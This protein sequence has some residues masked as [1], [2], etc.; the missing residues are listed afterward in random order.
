MFS[1]R[2]AERADAALLSTLGERLFRAAFGASNTDEDMQLYV[3]SAFSA[4]RQERELADA[5]TRTWLVEVESGAEIGYAMVRL[6]A[7]G[8]D[9]DAK[10]TVENVRFYVDTAFHGR[11]VASAL[12]NT[13]IE[14]AREW[15]CDQLWL[16]VWDKNARAIAFYK[17]SG[18]RVVGTQRFRLGNDRQRDFV[19]VRPVDLQEGQSR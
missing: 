5:A 2:R 14:Q 7:P 3:Q 11:G 16:G 13:C 18:F 6:G 15:G 1:I 12:M 17:K 10:N 4:K 8:A 9:F 19:M